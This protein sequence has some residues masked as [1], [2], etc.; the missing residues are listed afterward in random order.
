MD[1]AAGALEGSDRG[2][3]GCEEG[4]GGAAA[5][6]LFPGGSLRGTAAACLLLPGGSLRGTAA[7]CLLLPGG[8]SR[9]TV[10]LLRI[11]CA[12]LVGF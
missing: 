11:C 10:A 6:L 3:V 4:L 1:P 7:A 8:S 12:D 9:G 2:V 5:C